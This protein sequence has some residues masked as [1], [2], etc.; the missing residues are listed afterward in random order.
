MSRQ[1]ADDRSR[2]TE[3]AKPD[4]LPQQLLKQVLSAT[5]EARRGNTPRHLK[6][7][8]VIDRWRGT[9]WRCD[10]IGVSLVRAALTDWLANVK[11]SQDAQEKLVHDIANTLFE[12]PNASI[13][14]EAWWRELQ[15]SKG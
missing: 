10:T 12:D 13:K 7:Q 6:Y 9:P 14:L 5:A 3:D 2:P 15:E 1:F 4:D 8:P 11:L